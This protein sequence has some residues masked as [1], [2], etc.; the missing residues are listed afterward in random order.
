MWFSQSILL[1]FLIQSIVGDDEV[2][3]TIPQG[4]LK[5]IKAF[6]ATQNIPYYS[7]RGVPFAK[8]RVGPTKFD[9]SK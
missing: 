9:V 3:V 8:P 5:G 1:C 2:T 7:F 6:T 4:T